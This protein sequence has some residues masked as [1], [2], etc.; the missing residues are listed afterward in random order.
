MARL[1]SLLIAISLCRLSAGLHVPGDAFDVA[2]TTGNEVTPPN[3]NGA[4]VEDTPPPLPTSEPPLDDLVEPQA[5][6]PVENAGDAAPATPPPEDNVAPQE[7][8]AAAPVGFGPPEPEQETPNGDAGVAA[9]AEDAATER[10]IEDAVP[11]TPQANDFMHVD[12][13]QPLSAAAFATDDQQPQEAAETAPPAEAPAVEPEVPAEDQTNAEA[14]QQSKTAPTY[15]FV[16]EKKDIQKEGGATK[17]DLEDIVDPRNGKI[18][19]LTM[20]IDQEWL[21]KENAAN[22]IQNKMPTGT[23]FSYN[24]GAKVLTPVIEKPKVMGGVLQT[25]IDKEA[26]IRRRHEHG[27]RIE[28][29]LKLF[30]NRETA[31]V[32]GLLT[33]GS[34]EELKKNHPLVFMRLIE[35]LKASLALSQLSNTAKK[36]IDKFDRKWYTAASPKEKANLLE[37]IRKDTGVAELFQS[38]VKKPTNMTGKKKLVYDML[39]GFFNDFQCQ[40]VVRGNQV[41]KQILRMFDQQSGLYVAPLYTDLVPTLGSQW[42]IAR[43]EKFYRQTDF[44]RRDAMSKALPQM[45]GRFMAMVENGT[46]LPTSSELQTTLYSLSVVL[47]RIMDSVTEPRVF[48][49]KKK[50]YGYMGICDTTCLKGILTDRPGGNPKAKFFLNK[51]REILRWISLYL[52]NDLLK[53]DTMAQKLL[54]QLMFRTTGDTK[55]ILSRKRIEFGITSEYVKN[56]EKSLLEIPRRGRAAAANKPGIGVFGMRFLSGYRRF[57]KRVDN[58]M[59]YTGIAPYNAFKTPNKIVA[60]IDDGLISMIEVITDVV[61]LKINGEVN[62]LFMHSFNTWVQL[63]TFHAAIHSFE[64]VTAKNKNASKTMG[65]IF[66][67]LNSNV[68]AHIKSIPMQFLP[69]TS[70]ILQMSFFLQNSVEGYQRTKA[71]AVKNILRG[72]ASLSLRGKMGPKSFAQLYQY[73]QPHVVYNRAK[74]RIS[75]KVLGGLVNKFKS[76]FLAKPAIPSPV[77]QLITVFVGQWAKG[78]HEKLELTNPDIDRVR[79]NF[80]LSFVSNHAGMSEV[81]ADMIMQ[82]CKPV[83]GVLHLGCISKYDKKVTRCKQISIKMKKGSVLKAMEM[84]DAV[85][86][87]PLDVIRVG[88]DTARRCMAQ[89]LLRTQPGEEN[90]GGPAHRDRLMIFSEVAHRYHCYT[91]QKMMVNRLKKALLRRKGNDDVGA[92]IDQ[93]FST[94]RTISIKQADMTGAGTKL[95]C[96]FMDDAPDEMREKHRRKIVEYVSSKLTLRNRVVLGLNDLHSGAGNTAKGGDALPSKSNPLDDLVGCTF[97]GTRNYDGIL[98]YGGYA[99]PEKIVIPEGITLNPG[100]GRLVYDGEAFTSELDVLH[101]TSSVSAIT[102]EKR[103]NVTRRMYH[104]EDGT[105]MDE[106]AFGLYAN[107]FIVKAHVLM[108][109]SA[110]EKMGYKIGRFIWCGYDHGWV[111]DFALHDVIGNTDVPVFNGRYWV[112]SKQMIV[113]DLVGKNVNIKNGE[114]IKEAKLA[115]INVDVY[116]GDGKKIANYPSK[117]GDASSFIK[118]GSEATFTFDTGY[119]DISPAAFEQLVKHAQF[120]PKSNTLVINLDAPGMVLRESPMLSKT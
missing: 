75:R 61:N 32:I 107:D 20:G 36:I 71:G 6:A 35:P 83:T 94:M 18:S 41:A 84:L 101:D 82:H 68:N 79:K 58:N 7:L 106:L 29:D 21:N 5:A 27:V 39:D 105:V 85:F 76:M 15:G 14:P 19:N 100:D 16:Y 60:S 99:P 62:G 55:Y 40:K 96:P 65:A 95:V 91:A 9:P 28:H 24:R 1:H 33:R 97:V 98:Y 69:F 89:S 90:I 17:L 23:G 8:P 12:E 77:I 80:F 48:L 74:Y 113:T 10:P 49:G 56:N 111:V 37:N 3:P 109:A 86:E 31:D 63:Q 42:M 22:S 52:R 73:F 4:T 34:M 59:L 110:I 47:S 103:K 44:L 53:I 93:V 66:R 67:F 117:V 88:S 43:F 26:E 92:L 78:S 118:S 87:D 45:I 54:L 46:V 81:A 25:L 102:M 115:D 112:L 51:Q 120:D 108:T 104:L 72:I 119:G 116:S 70:L 30:V 114:Q 64:K 50:Y 2:A 57:G 13:I 11:Q 38:K